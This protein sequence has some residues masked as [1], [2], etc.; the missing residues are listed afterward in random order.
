MTEPPTLTGRI[1]KWEYF[2]KPE[3]NHVVSLAF[4][5]NDTEKQTQLR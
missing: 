1:F 3:H 2:V 5:T 4:G